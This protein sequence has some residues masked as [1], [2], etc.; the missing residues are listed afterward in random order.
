MRVASPA[1]AGPHLA[2]TLPQI[3][4]DD[5]LACA[6]VARR[7]IELLFL[8]VESA[9]REGAEPSQNPGVVEIMIGEGDGLPER[10]GHRLAHHDPGERLPT[11][12]HPIL[13]LNPL[14][15]LGAPCLTGL[16]FWWRLLMLWAGC[17]CARAVGMHVW[18]QGRLDPRS[19]G[20]LGPLGR[21]GLCCA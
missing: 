1:Y 11:A 17:C 3:L 4:R 15:G 8:G 21:V 19:T 10:H 5:R 12:Q 16:R 2:Q 18:G 14:T 13:S 20:A 7:T 9:S 6:C